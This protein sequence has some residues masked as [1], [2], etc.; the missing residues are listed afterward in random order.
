MLAPMAKIFP[1]PKQTGMPLNQVA[2]GIFE[3]MFV[4]KLGRR[5]G[6]PAQICIQQPK[7]SGQPIDIGQGL[8]RGPG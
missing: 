5:E 3:I 1:A 4:Q 7:L 8:D 2:K 6:S